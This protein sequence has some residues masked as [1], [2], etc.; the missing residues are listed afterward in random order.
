MDNISVET[1]NNEKTAIKTAVFSMLSNILL[2]IIKG[3]AGYFGN[4]YALIADAIE[5]TTDVFSSL[6][7]FLGLKYSSRPAD[8][9]HPYGHG[10]AESLV[11]IIVA[12]FL[13]ISA[14]III[15]NNLVG[16]FTPHK[17]P[18][19]WTLFVLGPIIIWK[20][21]SYQLVV[22]KSK[23]T[24]SSSL[25]ADAWHHRSDAITSVAAFIGI[26]IAL[27]FGKSFVIADNIAALFAA[28]FIIYNSFLIFRPAFGEIMDEDIYEDL[29]IKIEKVS[30]TVKG[31]IDT[32]KCFIRKA[33][34]KYHV[35][36][37]VTIDANTTVKEGHRLA[38]ELNNTLKKEIPELANVLVHIE[39]S[40]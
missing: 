31:I 9:N 1:M 10:R 12:G 33:G 21:I 22:K 6:L 11:A 40:E 16:I 23:E 26:S 14:L 17:L 24:N 8:E 37:H 3:T 5:S 28:S 39:P 13:L 36:L 20:E 29:V 25:K 35:D 2:A 18:N 19:Y 38:H 7:V 15:R 32:E 27:I 30:K 34:M 4:S